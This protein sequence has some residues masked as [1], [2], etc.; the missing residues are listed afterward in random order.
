VAPGQ[1]AVG[2]SAP[3]QPLV[4]GGQGHQRGRRGSTGTT[5][6]GTAATATRVRARLV[7]GS[8]VRSVAA[9]PGRE[10]ELRWPPRPACPPGPPTAPGGRPTRPAHPA[11]RSPA[12]AREA[13]VDGGGGSDIGATLAPRARRP[14]LWP[15][16]AK[17]DERPPD[18]R[19]LALP[20]RRRRTHLLGTDAVTADRRALSDA[21]QGVRWS[22]SSRS[23][24]VVVPPRSV[25]RRRRTSTRWKP[26]TRRCPHEDLRR[27]FLSSFW[28][29]RSFVERWLGQSDA[30]RSGAAR[31]RSGS[32]TG[33]GSSPT[34]ASRR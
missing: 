33:S 10:A 26:T 19:P 9:R 17:G 1:H 4:A 3:G 8:T 31:R 23:R 13:V 7:R 28:P 15:A 12:A 34:P 5:R 16:A 20:S 18:R 11:R 21:D 27:R 24:S 22:N 2:R 32:R 25:R 6:A 30:G 14:T 29:R